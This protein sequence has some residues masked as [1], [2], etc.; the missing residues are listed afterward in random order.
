MLPNGKK[1]V[2]IQFFNLFIMKNS[3][4]STAQEAAQPKN[5]QQENLANKENGKAKTSYAQDTAK[6]KEIA[7]RKKK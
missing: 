5:I 7:K 2:L 6:N 4:K 3:K 1:H